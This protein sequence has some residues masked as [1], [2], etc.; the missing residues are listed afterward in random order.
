MTGTH[1][2]TKKAL[3]ICVWIG[4]WPAYLPYFTKTASQLLSINWLL[5]SD[6]FK[7]CRFTGKYLI[8]NNIPLMILIF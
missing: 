8:F 2:N 5:V 3:I 4:S 6:Q 7:T 1:S